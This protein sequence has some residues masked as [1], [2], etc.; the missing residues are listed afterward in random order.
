MPHNG[1]QI[2]RLSARVTLILSVLA[3]LCVLS[4][5]TQPPQADEGAAAHIFQ[6]S[7]VAL[8][9]MILLFLASADW[10]DP[11]A[12]HARWQ[13]L[14]LRCFLLSRPCVLPLSITASPRGEWFTLPAVQPRTTAE[15]GRARLFG[16]SNI[17]VRILRFR[18]LGTRTFSFQKKVAESG[19]EYFQARI[20]HINS[21]GKSTPAVSWKHGLFSA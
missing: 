7:I 20:W 13:Y 8:V 6:L 14:P 12:G 5:Y 16:R 2:N 10:K 18:I 19:Q 9:P 11:R 17:G 4:G 15:I 1:Q 21:C 3:L